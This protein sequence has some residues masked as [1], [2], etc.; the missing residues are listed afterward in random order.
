MGVLRFRLF[1]FPVEIQPGFWL[2]AAFLGMDIAKSVPEFA[3]WVTIVLASFLG[4]ELGHAIVARRF[5]QAPRIALYMMGGVTAWSPTRELGRG[6]RILVTLAGPFAG[7]LLAAVAGAGVLAVSHLGIDSRLAAFALRWTLLAN[8]FWST[9][10]L[11]PVLP[12][13][14]GQVMAA[15]LGPKRVKLAASLSLV[16]GLGLAAILWAR[17]GSVFGAAVFAFGAVSSYLAM[18]RTQAPAPPPPEVL[19][20]VLAQ[21]RGALDAGQHAQAAAM[22]RAVLAATADA[23]IAHRA[24]ELIVWAALGSGDVAAAR[25]A[26]GDARAPV[27]P[28]LEGAVR[29][30]DGEL[31]RAIGVLA[32][33]HDAGDARPELGALLVK[34]LL[35]RKSFEEA[36]RVALKLV[37]QVPEG[38]LREVAAQALAG[39]AP[40]RAARLWEALF[41]RERQAGDAWDAA[42]AFSRAGEPERAIEALA[43]AIGGGAPADRV[44]EDPDLSR[45]AHDPRFEHALRGDAL[46]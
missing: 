44:R 10:N 21:A 32:R 46:G 42:R 9:L 5:G 1:G 22:A 31:E 2:L 28:L 11:A 30:A 12:F 29:E 25:A 38:E 3:V 15:A 13:D 8:L 4:H 33:A 17:Y 37:G 16:F 7:F 6:R 27:D 23:A 26:L 45:L 40:R 18:Q 43:S 24:G 19:E 34:V 35:A 41:E 20:S 14:G 36:G 39:G